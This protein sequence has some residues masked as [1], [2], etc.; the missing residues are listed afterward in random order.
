MDEL[1]DV[2]RFHTEKGGM[3]TLP[4]RSMASRGIS[5]STGRCMSAFIN[6]CT[7]T[8]LLREI[9]TGCF[10]SAGSVAIFSFVRQ[11]GLRVNSYFIGIS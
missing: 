8:V 4:T 7:H 3:P 10:R 11:A 1:L 5:M 6:V 2:L 9:G